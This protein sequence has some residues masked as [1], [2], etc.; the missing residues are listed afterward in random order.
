MI[1]TY[2]T[3]TRLSYYNGTQMNTY[4]FLKILLAA[5]LLNLVA[6]TQKPAGAEDKREFKNSLITF[7][8]FMRKAEHIA[9][10]Y[11]A[12][13]FIPGALDKLKQPCFLSAI[14]RNHS[15]KVIWLELD[16]WRFTSTSGEVVRLKRSYWNKQWQQLN[17]PMAHRSTFGWT[18]LPEQRDLR[19]HE[20]VGGSLSLQQ[21]DKLLTLEA[22]FSTGP[23]KKGESF[24]VRFEGLRCQSDP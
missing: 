19:P 24:V 15:D 23:D 8:V 12:R 21:T 17:V 2:L 4:S 6:C 20:P 1:N 22:H 9:A 10:F 11:E 18:Q 3:V 5:L 7:K 14:I 13:G 16:N